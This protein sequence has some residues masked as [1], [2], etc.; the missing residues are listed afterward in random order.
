V[1]KKCEA[2]KQ[3]A[4]KARLELE[5]VT[6]D[7]NVEEIAIEENNQQTMKYKKC[8]HPIGIK[9]AKAAVK[10]ENKDTKI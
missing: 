9:A 1:V 2:G 5:G 10:A 4:K 6:A 8:Q 7:P 3:Q